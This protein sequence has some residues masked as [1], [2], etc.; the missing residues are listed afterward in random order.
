MFPT[1]G[2]TSIGQWVL[3]AALVVVLVFAPSVVAR[4]VTAPS[5]PVDFMREPWHGWSFAG[6]VLRESLRA[7]VASPGE[8]LTAAQRRWDGE[9]GRP[10]A[11]RVELLYL[12]GS[13]PYTV[14][15][16]RAD[17]QVRPRGPLAWQ[18]LGH[19]GEQGS[20]RVIG[21]VDFTSGEF[22]WDVADEGA[23]APDAPTATGKEAAQ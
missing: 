13:R 1:R 8:A 15:G 21:M 3:I 12:P 22:L 10:Q 5:E 6:I 7:E 19:E 16:R 4:S 23:A 2:R 17:P 14:P 20:E 11:S 9:Q 18:V